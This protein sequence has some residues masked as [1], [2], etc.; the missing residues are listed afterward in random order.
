MKEKFLYICG[1][2]KCP[3]NSALGSIY[4]NFAVEL[5]IN[6]YTEEIIDASCVLITDLGRNFVKSLLVGRNFNTEFNQIINDIELYYQAVPQ[7][8]LISA[9]KVALNR[10]KQTR[11]NI[12]GINSIDQTTRSIG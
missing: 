1:N 2:S 11:Q 10:Y 4:Q 9:L 6:V 3:D 8:A 5:V 7:K 12:I